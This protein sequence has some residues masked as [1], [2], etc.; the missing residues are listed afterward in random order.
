MN[1]YLIAE[2]F[3]QMEPKYEPL[4]SRSAPYLSN[5]S[6]DC[7]A[8]ITTTEESYRWFEKKYNTNDRA[9]IE[10]M[11]TGAEFYEMLLNHSGL[12]LHSSAVEYEGCAYLFSAPSGTG[13]STHTSLWLKEHP[14]SVILNDDK[15]AIRILSDGIYV[16]GTPWSGK[17]DLNLN[18]KVKLR[19]ICFLSRG[20]ENKIQ[21]ADSLFSI[22]NILEQT[23]RPRSS[24]KKVELMN[25]IDRLVREI[26]IYRMECNMDPEAARI[27][28]QTMSKEK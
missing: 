22:R 6:A 27:S 23:V 26:P 3:I 16:Y 7:I 10:Y 5:K 9:L 17:T 14:G 18:R 19:S 4:L 2:L 15:P 11:A 25:L 24:A 12:L 8:D 13:K 21:E 1:R 28:Y 20:K